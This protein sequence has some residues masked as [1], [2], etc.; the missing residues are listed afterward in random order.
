MKRSL[1]LAAAIA[2]LA[3]TTQV[4]AVQHSVS[5]SALVAASCSVTGTPTISGSGFTNPT[6]ASSNFAATVV[7]GIAQS[8]IGTITFPSVVCT[9]GNIKATLDP[10]GTAIVNSIAMPSGNN[11]NRIDYTAEVK[12][13]ANQ[14]IVAVN[15][16]NNTASSSANSGIASDAITLKI[17]IA[18]T[19]SGKTLLPGSY[20]GTLKLDIDPI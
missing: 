6:L 17:T 19:P 4:G 18:A 2:T 7:N 12:T 3:G 9:G 13:S 1:I 5:L 11:I 16:A 20:L 8:T 14:Q 10:L 15:T